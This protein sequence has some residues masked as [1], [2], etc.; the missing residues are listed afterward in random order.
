M[1]LAAVLLVTWSWVVGGKEAP[2]F[3][4]WGTSEKS[5]KPLTRC[6]KNQTQSFIQLSKIWKSKC[7]FNP[8]ILENTIDKRWKYFEIENENDKEGGENMQ[9]VVGLQCLDRPV[10]SPGA[11]GVFNLFGETCFKENL[12]GG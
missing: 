5:S 11:Y 6:K 7:D 3:E 4:R 12:Q 10:P 9:T 1:R 2:R 8:K